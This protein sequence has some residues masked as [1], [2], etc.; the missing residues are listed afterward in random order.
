[1]PLFLY[2]KTE[3]FLFYCV[4]DTFALT[5][6]MFPVNC[7]IFAAC[8]NYSD[9]M[10]EKLKISSYASMPESGYSMQALVVSGSGGMKS[11][12]YSDMPFIFDGIAFGICTAGSAE[13]YVNYRKYEVKSG[14]LLTV[15]PRQ[16]CS[17]ESHSPDFSVKLL[18]LHFQF[19]DTVSPLKDINMLKH[20]YDSPL[21]DA[22]GSLPEELLELYSLIGRYSARNE[23]YLHDTIVSS[24][25]TA[26][27]CRVV[28]D[29]R[30]DC[31]APAAARHRSRKE[32]ITYRFFRLLSVDFMC[33]RD[34]AFYAGKLCISA[35][36]LTTAVS[37]VTG[38]PASQWI[39]TA[40]L[41]EIKQRLR[42][43]SCTVASIAEDMNFPTASALSRYFRRY[44]GMTPSD[45]R[46]R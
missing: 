21:R 35:K 6:F 27:V 37:E 41:T 44:T 25:I 7:N 2:K 15:M 8:E 16:I 33:S 30:N 9:A 34:V 31:K 17:A 45:Y 22:A 14:S 23:L 24:L 5:S 46:G 18:L 28:S 42:L 32:E 43:G 3:I 19:A 1:M 40:V 20:I 36:Y 13:V 26:F 11:R 29:Y 10:G 4:S 12:I 38:V 39:N